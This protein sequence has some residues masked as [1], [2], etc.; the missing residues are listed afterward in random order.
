MASEF[1]K[2]CKATMPFDGTGYTLRQQ[3]PPGDD[4]AVPRIDNNVDMLNE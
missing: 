3:E 2:G 1:T 4:I